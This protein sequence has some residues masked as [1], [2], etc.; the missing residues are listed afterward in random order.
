V[1]FGGE[2]DVPKRFVSKEELSW[3]MADAHAQGKEITLI[4][5]ERKNL[6]EFFLDIVKGKAC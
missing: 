1:H 4:E 6:E 5:P 3:F 2:E